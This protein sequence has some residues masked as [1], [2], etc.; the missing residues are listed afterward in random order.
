MLSVSLTF[1]GD[2]PSISRPLV[3]PQTLVDGDP[4][5][6]GVRVVGRAARDVGDG[7]LVVGRAPELEDVVVLLGHAVPLGPLGRRVRLVTSFV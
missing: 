1:A 3:V 2:V 6:L 4:A 5:V 7:D